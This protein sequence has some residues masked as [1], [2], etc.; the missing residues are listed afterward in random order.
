[1]NNPK[2]NG[3]RE[4]VAALAEELKWNMTNNCGIFRTESKM[5]HGLEIIEALQERF[6]AA[7][8]TDKTSRFN[9]DVL[10]AL[11]T[12]NLLT[13][14]KVVVTSAL[15][16]QESRGAHAR[17]DFTTRDD[18]RWLKH[19]VALMAADGSP[20]LTYRDVCIDYERYPPQERKY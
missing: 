12:E 2:A 17:E 4:N 1:M 20:E 7:E 9:T 13:F 19:T 15:A 16:R 8:V 14:S 11:E 6:A 10:M 5:S 18:E 3:Q